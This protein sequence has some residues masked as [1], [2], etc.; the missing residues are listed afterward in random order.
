M[1]WS[2][3]VML[4]IKDRKRTG[5]RENGRPCGKARPSIDTL[6][7]SLGCIDNSPSPGEI[8]S[9]I[10]SGEAGSLMKAAAPGGTK[11]IPVSAGFV[12][13]IGCITD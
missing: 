12:P 6:T 4:K 3:A 1:G 9:F 10:T 7:M 8:T 5:L 11:A 2:A 13:D